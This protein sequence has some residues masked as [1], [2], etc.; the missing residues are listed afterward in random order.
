MKVLPIV[1]LGVVLIGGG[2]TSKSGG[3]DQP[4]SRSNPRPRIPRVTSPQRDPLD[5][6]AAPDPERPSDTAQEIARLRSEERQKKVAADTEKLVELT[7]D[8]SAQMRQSNA[9]TLSADQLKK[10]EAIEKLA[11]SVKERMKS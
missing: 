5:I 6:T 1:L 9:D 7:K 4:P 10:L 2:F 8:L 11:H 3:Q